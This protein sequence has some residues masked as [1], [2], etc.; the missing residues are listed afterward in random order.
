MSFITLSYISLLTCLYMFVF[1]F[2]IRVAANIEEMAAG[3]NKRRLIQH[4][5]F[6]ELCKVS[7]LH[8]VYICICVSADFIL[9]IITSNFFAHS[10]LI[11]VLKHGIQAKE[12]I[13]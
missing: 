1:T 11:L 5:V 10:W 8:C 7:I 4:T 9:A 2:H 12:K 13:M 6:Q 3:T